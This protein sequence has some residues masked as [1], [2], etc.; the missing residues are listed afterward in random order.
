MTSGDIAAAQ[1]S[2]TTR[3]LARRAWLRAATV[4][5]AGLLAMAVLFHQEAAAAVRVWR[6][7]T[8]FGHCFLV[9]PI[10]AWL[11]WER[12]GAL[13]GLVPRPVPM[14]AWL[15][16]PLAAL[17]FAAERLGIMEGRQFA[18][19]FLVW[20]L[21][22][23]TLGF[24]VCRAMAAPLAYT[25]FL[26]PFGAFLVP[27]LQDF[28]ARFID[29]GLTVLDI[30]HLVTAT[31][32]EIPEG[33]FRVA[34]A[35]AGLRFLIAAIAFGTLYACIIYRSAW[36]RAAFI[37]V[38][39]VVPILANGLRALGIVLLGHIKGSAEAG[40]VDHI[41]YG[42]LFFSLVI[43]LLLLLGLPFRQDAAPPIA[44]APRR[45][46]GPMPRLSALAAAAVAVVALAAIGP[47]SSALLNQRALAG[48]AAAAADGER[49]AAALVTP[50]GCAA[51]PS[52]Q[53][54]RGFVCDGVRL[55]ATVRVFDGRSGPAALR[56]WRDA[57]GAGAAEDAETS[58][59]DG[60]GARWR[61]VTTRTPDRAVASAL[62]RDGVPAPVG[63]ALRLRLAR[64]TFAFGDHVLVLIE[65]SATSVEPVAMAALA[66]LIAAQA[67]PPGR[68]SPSS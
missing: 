24:A 23:C 15:A 17:W 6:D 7:S 37:A 8:A 55:A 44:R 42:W 10:V 12:R 22:V 27:P 30:P 14:L 59:R 48:S 34:E 67:G 40:A 56:A 60:P 58:W 47:A 53:G 26:V 16:L 57:G 19:L 62:W 66:G 28:T 38:C 13:A 4:L 68:G 45:A 52:A 21:V 9:G 51:E 29:A 3:P 35:C 5:G 32:I 1:A 65:F 18:A 25:V 20:L 54:R 63:L 36:R 64:D 41:L 46:S 61:V 2:P 49:L 50:P 31:L 11:A 39:V 33:N 43:L